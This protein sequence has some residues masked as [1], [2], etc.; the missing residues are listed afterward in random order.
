MRF[1]NWSVSRTISYQHG[2]LGPCGAS[3]KGNC[4]GWHREKE[5]QIQEESDFKA[6]G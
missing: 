6:N 1:E 3:T 2:E 5:E 4:R